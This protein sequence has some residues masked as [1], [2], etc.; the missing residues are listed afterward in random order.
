MLLFDLVCVI[1]LQ[2]LVYLM[3]VMVGKVFRD[4]ELEAY[5]LIRMKLLC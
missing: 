2:P 1:L 4:G 3:E 5:A